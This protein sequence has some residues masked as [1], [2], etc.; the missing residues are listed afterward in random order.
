MV[1]TMKPSRRVL[2]FCHCSFRA[3]VRGASLLFREKIITVTEVT[4]IAD[5]TKD[6][7]KIPGTKIVVCVCVCVFFPFI[8]DIKF[9]GRTSRGHN[10]L[11]LFSLS[12][13]VINVSVQY[14]G[15]FLFWC[16]FMVINVS[17]QYYGGFLFWCFIFL[18]NKNKRLLYLVWN[19]ALLMYVGIFLVHVILENPP[20]LLRSPLL[21]TYCVLITAALD[22]VLFNA[23]YSP[24]GRED[25]AQS[26]ARR[27]V[28]IRDVVYKAGGGGQR[29]PS[30]RSSSGAN[31]SSREHVSQARRFVSFG[32]CDVLQKSRLY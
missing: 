6:T 19:M 31:G 13:M 29:R 7:W 2:S 32:F 22:D 8:L 30:G 14:N 4:D 26:Y 3:Q 11:S 12:F 27:V 18:Q 24:P 16:P 20:P 5:I 9:V 1:L 21:I 23:I 25:E 10:S 17:V 28:T 15:G